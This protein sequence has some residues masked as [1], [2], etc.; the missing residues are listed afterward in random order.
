MNASQLISSLIRGFRPAIRPNISHHIHARPVAR[1]PLLSQP[2]GFRAPFT[3]SP[4]A[5]PPQ[6]EESTSSPPSAS[7]LTEGP[8]H[9]R[10]SPP[11]PQAPR[12]LGRGRKE[13][14]YQLTFTCKPCKHRSSHEMSRQGY[15]HGTVLITCPEC[16]NRHVISDHLNVRNAP[17]PSWSSLRRETM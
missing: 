2:R 1:R 13:P 14:T 7:S 4:T 8:P 17:H 3:T 5:T 16:K 6:P 12:P 9:A 15:H 11:S 10:Y